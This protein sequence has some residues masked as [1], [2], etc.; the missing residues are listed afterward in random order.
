MWTQSKQKIAATLGIHFIQRAN[1][2]FI[3]D[4]EVNFSL[5]FRM[6]TEYRLSKWR[7]TF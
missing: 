3:M 7:A 1:N 5:P 6:H 4:L 2:W